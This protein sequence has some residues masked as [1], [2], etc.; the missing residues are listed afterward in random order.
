MN[1]ASDPGPGGSPYANETAIR[2]GTLT[3]NTQIFGGTAEAN[4]WS[5]DNSATNQTNTSY[6]FPLSGVGNNLGALPRHNSDR[7]LISN[8]SA[9][10]AALRMD[11][12]NSSFA[13]LVADINATL[14][15][16][17]S[18]IT[19]GATRMT[20][21]NGI[22]THFGSLSNI[23]LDSNGRQISCTG[24]IALNG[25]GFTDLDVDNVVSLRADNS[26]TAGD[27]RMFVYDVDNAT[28]ERVTV[29]AADSGGVGFKV[30]RIPN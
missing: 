28:L 11:F 19:N 13:S 14:T 30:L 1:P 26:S 23:T 5:V 2:L 16:D 10:P 3:E 25:V 20:W 9:T 15:K 12:I 8:I 18:V 24:N 29:G 27:T 22:T 6:G 21:F 7:V 4:T 17:L